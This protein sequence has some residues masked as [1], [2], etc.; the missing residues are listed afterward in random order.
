[1]MLKTMN[2]TAHRPVD[3]AES[4]GTRSRKGEVL[5]LPDQME[6]VEQ[7]MNELAAGDNRHRITVMV[8]DH[9][10]TGGKRIRALLA[11]WAT[12]ALGGS[13]CAG[14]A[15]AAACEMLHNASLVHDDL[16]DGD[17]LRRGQPTVW[18]R[19]GAAQAVN[20]GDLMLMLPFLALEH[21]PI[22]DGVRW[23][24]SRLLA[25]GAAETVRGQSDEM[26]LLPCELLDVENYVRVVEGKT[27]AL[28]AMPVQGAALISGMSP[29]DAE[30]LAAPFRLIGQ[31]FQLQ[32]DVVD[33]YGEKGRAERGSD[34]REGKVS[35]LVVEHLAV[36]PE[37]RTRL[38]SLLRTPRE[39]TSSTEVQW[40]IDAFVDS[41]AL[42]RVIARIEDL[43]NAV[44]HSP[45]L[46]LH[47]ALNRVAHTL[48]EQCLRPI[49][50]LCAIQYTPV[51]S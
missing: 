3:L 39:T 46:G 32:D 30:N 8:Q 6:R 15:W 24:L 5:Q 36:C 10:S 45:V 14:V 48:L 49:G 23:K 31:I 17:T 21:G 38:L 16:Q 34:L 2:D 51:A 33:L 35:A 12:R 19:Y 4:A 9:L 20:V 25:A 13:P 1:M 7:L 37:D 43:A 44:H 18:S 27:A 26:D 22:D 11:L 28:L 50:H 29:Q 41:G 42:D 40:A 47:P